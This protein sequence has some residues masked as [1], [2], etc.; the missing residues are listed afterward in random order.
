MQAGGSD[1]QVKFIVWRAAGQPA[2]SAMATLRINSQYLASLQLD[3]HTRGGGAF[4]T[5]AKI[6]IQD[7][8]LSLTYS[9]DSGRRLMLTPSASLPEPHSN[10][11]RLTTFDWCRTRLWLHLRATCSEQPVFQP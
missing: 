1:S 3:L 9:S 2:S 6:S 8:A 11:A 10:S 4:A 7:G 5:G